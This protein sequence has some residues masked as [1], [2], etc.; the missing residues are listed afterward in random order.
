MT[1]VRIDDRMPHHAKLRDAGE[2]AGWLWLCG[3]CWCNAQVT[4]GHIRASDLPCLYP[5]RWTAKEL[6]ALAARLVE[7]R[8]W[9]PEPGGFLVNGYAEEQREAMRDRVE[10]RKEK[11]RKRK[12]VHLDSARIPNGGQAEA[13]RIPSLPVPVPVPVP[14]P[15]RISGESSG[16]LVARGSAPASVRDSLA[17][18]WRVG[19]VRRFE[20]LAGG[21]H[22]GPRG[23]YLANL[24]DA[25]ATQPDPAAF[26]E[27]ALDGFFA[28]PRHATSRPAFPVKYL[29][30]DPVGYAAC[31]TAPTGETEAH[32]TELV[33][34]IPRLEV[35]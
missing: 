28:T 19:F 3:L 4:D 18:A 33:R 14:D 8:L 25:A 17:S 12:G 7:L 27:R 1:W 34:G 24:I 9:H 35:A 16:D 21:T 5:G 32:A 20:R 23:G 22:E 13:N 31:A 10:A 15:D 26:V 30:E 11:D 29:A 2:A 6:A